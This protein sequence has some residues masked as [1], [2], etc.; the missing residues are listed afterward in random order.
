V[1]TTTKTFDCVEMKNRIQANILANYEAHKDEF[2]SFRA[3]IRARNSQSAWVR[4]MERKFRGSEGQ[5]S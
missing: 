2:P 1:R 5:Q 4:R 3:F